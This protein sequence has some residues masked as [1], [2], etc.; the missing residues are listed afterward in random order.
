MY[1]SLRATCE[2]FG[3]ISCLP[4]PEGEIYPIH[5]AA[6]IGCPNLWRMLLKK[7]ANPE[8]DPDKPFCFGSCLEP[9]HR[10]RLT[11]AKLH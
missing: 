4:T 9:P 5:V 11:A 3:R 2:M 10:R 6:A 7:G 1:L 8:Q